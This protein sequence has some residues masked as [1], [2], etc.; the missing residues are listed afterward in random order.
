MTDEKDKIYQQRYVD[1]CI[2]NNPESQPLSDR[3]L[4]EIREGLQEEFELTKAIEGFIPVVSEEE[5]R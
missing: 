3:R 5:K 4:E 1:W 2:S